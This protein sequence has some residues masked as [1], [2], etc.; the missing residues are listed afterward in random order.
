MEPQLEQILPAD[1][2]APG[3]QVMPEDTFITA[4]QPFHAFHRYIY[5]KTGV[6]IEELIP[7]FQQLDTQLKKE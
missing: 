7:I 2:A 1:E 4:H 6:W 3:I 5:E